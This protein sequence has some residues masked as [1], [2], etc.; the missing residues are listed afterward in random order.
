LKLDHIINSGNDSNIKADNSNEN[1]KIDDNINTFYKEL[2]NSRDNEIETNVSE[3]IYIENYKQIEINDENIVNNDSDSEEEIISSKKLHKN[4]IN[5]D[6]DSEEEIINFNKKHENIAKDSDSDE[7][8]I[9]SKEKHEDLVNS[10][11][12]EEIIS[13]IKKHKRMV[14]DEEEE[15]IQTFK[16]KRRV[17]IFDDD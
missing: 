5:D 8:I 10:D 12:D 13:S 14:I 4:I 9:S 16:K 1:P 11:S 7:E 2:N 17:M 3:S 15:T 6:S